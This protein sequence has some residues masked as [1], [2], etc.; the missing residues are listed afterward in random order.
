MREPRLL[1]LFG[2]LILSPGQA[3]A[4][5]RRGEGPRNDSAR[6]FQK[7]V[8]LW[9]AGLAT[10]QVPATS[11]N[12]DAPSSRV[13]IR[14]NVWAQP[15]RTPDGSWMIYV[16][17]KPVLDFLENPSEGTAKAYLGWKREQSEK[18]RKAMALLA[19]IKDSEMPR[20]GPD[21]PSDQAMPTAAPPGFTFRM[22]YFKKPACPHCISQDAV[23]AAWLKH[24]PQ[25]KV[26]VLLPGEREELWKA[27][28][29]RGTP[30]LVLECGS[31]A[32]KV[33][34]IGLQSEAALES[35]LGRLWADLEGSKDSKRK[36]ISR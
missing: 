6:F 1:L 27:Y 35:V 18:L 17:P 28:D 11:S 2:L 16:P 33:V 7:P 20:S 8:D 15:I 34:L 36:E 4:Q 26:E 13:A 5:E 14:E 10:L 21:N 3:S 32:R 29:V 24:R 19:R 23:L 31:P 25:G 30:T 22:T 12:E 9:N